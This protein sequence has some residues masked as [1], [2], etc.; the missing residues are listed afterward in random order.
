MRKY[1]TKCHILVVGVLLAILGLVFAGCTNPTALNTATYQETVDGVLWEV[2]YT[3]D[4]SE[5]VS[6]KTPLAMFEFDKESQFYTFM[7]EYTANPDTEVVHS[8]TL[9]GKPVGGNVYKIERT[10]VY[11]VAC[12]RADYEVIKATFPTCV[13][14]ET[15]YSYELINPDTGEVTT[16]TTTTT[17]VTF[18]SSVSTYEQTIIFNVPTA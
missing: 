15:P 16:V 9:S 13:Y 12:S 6:I 10:E 3:T 1:I 18:S 14:S 4:T 11:K 7:A 2:T 5:V 17:E 8:T